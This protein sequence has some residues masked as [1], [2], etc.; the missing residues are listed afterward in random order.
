MMFLSLPILFSPDFGESINLIEVP[1]FRRDMITAVLLL[2]FF[3]AN[4]YVFIPQFYVPRKFF[5]FSAILIASFLITALVPELLIVHHHPNVMSEHGAVGFRPPRKMGLLF[6]LSHRSLNFLMVLILS[7]LLKIR[8]RLKQTETEKANAELSYL[9]AQI[10]PHFLFN[11]LNSIYSLAIQKNDRTADAVVK[12]S[13]MMRYVLNDSNTNFVMLE[14]EI[15]YITSYIELQRMRLASNVKLS[16]I[17]EGNIGEKKI[18]PL[19][20]IPFIENA[21]KHGVNSEENSN[22]DIQILISDVHLKMSVKNNCVTTNNN[23]LNK[24]GLGIENTIA[25]LKLLYPKNYTLNISEADKTFTVSL[26][27]NIHD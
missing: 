17:H 21:F 23:T 1:F 2:I 9:K 22:I 13:D 20:L 18:A 24:S 15:N 6:F 26:T 25:R 5:I 19:V 8:E 11:T 10:N 14:K 27:L 12:L 4:Y 16:Y 7:L 3:Y